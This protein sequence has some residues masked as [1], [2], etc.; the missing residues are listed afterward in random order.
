MSVFVTLEIRRIHT[1]NGLEGSPSTFPIFD[2]THLGSQ[3]ILKQ[4]I[5][6]NHTLLDG[7]SIEDPTRKVFIRAHS[8]L[9]ELRFKVF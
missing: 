9:Q 6:L 7:I 8:H 4:A 2:F 5:S 1:G 3:S